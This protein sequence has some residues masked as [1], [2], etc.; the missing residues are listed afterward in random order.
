[1][2][3]NEFRYTHIS[4]TDGLPISVLRI[5]PD[6]NQKIKGIVQI[7]HGM[8]EHKGRYVEFM[9]YLAEHGYIAVV[10][11]LRG[12][13]ESVRAKDDL[14]YFY[15]GGYKAMI[16]DVHEIT[17]ETKKYVED[18]LGIT[19]GLK[20]NVEV[21]ILGDNALPPVSGI[22]YVLL[23]HSMGSMVIR[24]YIKEYDKDVDK[25]CVIGCPTNQGGL[26]A[27]LAFMK[28]LAFVKGEKSRSKIA[29]FMVM[30][31]NF[32]NKFKNE[33]KYAWLNSDPERTAEYDADPLSGFSFTLN[34]YVNLI[35]LTI[36][37]Y[38]PGGYALQNPDLEIKFFSGKE[39]PC[40][41]SYKAFREAMLHIKHQGY[42]N[43]SG[44]MYK[45]MRH[46]VLNERERIRVYRDISR[47]I[48]N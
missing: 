45:G 39:D 46:E 7:V 34:G 36:D 37:T 26:K 11:D 19:V 38:A 16:D 18:E 13:G 9:R 6:N 47:F 20:P 30:G 5:E 14:G 29:D 22:P 32:T 24:C 21:S 25:L 15:N 10:N 48:E 12:H 4:E 43:V 41:K 27:A 33:G 40:A 8:T 23:G 31:S 1:M 42:K 17:L 28:F 44:K 2:I 3:I 35:G